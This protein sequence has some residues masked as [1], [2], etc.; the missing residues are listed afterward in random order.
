MFSNHWPPA[1]I[2]LYIN[3]RSACDVQCLIISSPF[4]SRLG[5]VVVNVWLLPIDEVSDVYHQCR[6]SPFVFMI[7]I[8][9]WW[10]WPHLILFI[11]HMILQGLYKH[12]KSFYTLNP[13]LYIKAL[14]LISHWLLYRWQNNSVTF[15][16]C[17]IHNY[18]YQC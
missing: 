16:F 6:I 3:S 17:H 8:F 11:I 4:I 5:D 15:T 7:K 13:H 18:W 12:I 2:D 10:W 9:N 1:N 14:E